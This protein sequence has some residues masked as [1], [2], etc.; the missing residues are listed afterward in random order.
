MGYGT[1]RAMGR[2]RALLRAVSVAGIA[3][4]LTGCMKIDLDYHINADDTVDGT[5]IMAIDR[6]LAEFS[7]DAD[8]LVD[9]MLGDEG[10]PEGATA[11]RY[12]DDDYIGAQ[13]TLSD[14]PLDELDL[15]TG[16]AESLSITHEG[17]EYIASGVMD[18]SDTDMGGEFGDDAGAIGQGFLDSLEIRI[19]IT[20]PGEIIETNGEVDGTT[21]VWEPQV[22]ER[23]EIS[24]RAADSGG[25]GGLPVWAW[26]VIGVVVVA[27]IVGLAY[28]LTRSRKRTAA[29]SSAATA[30]GTSAG[31]PPP[32]AAQ[33]QPAAPPTAQPEPAAPP[34]A[35]PPQPGA[36][37]QA[38]PAEGP[39]DVSGVGDDG[40]TTETATGQDNNA[41]G[42]TLEPPR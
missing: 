5:M 16:D 11:E 36:G 9:E 37:T 30:A 35:A 3:V 26:I 2:R 7:G 10:I 42:D 28:V 6:D 22:G 20:F 12:E 27:A 34:P 14:V 23:V 31:Y 18:L 41:D 38:P 32:P 33:P 8:S 21:V 15:D 19:A 17:D 25:A 40:P 4:V 29:E 13:Y 24:A 1:I 39:Q